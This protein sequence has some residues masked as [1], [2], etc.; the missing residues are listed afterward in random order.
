MQNTPWF[1]RPARRPGHFRL[2]CLSYAGG[3]ARVFVPWQAALGPDVEICAIELPGR[4]TRVQETA[5]TAMDALIRELGRAV[6]ALQPRLPFAFFGHSLGALIA[7]E[8]AH[9][10]AASGHPAPERLFASGCPAPR[11]TMPSPRLHDLPDHEL[12]Q[13]LSELDGTPQEV[14]ANAEF[15]ALVLPTIRADL[16]ISDNYQ[17]LERTLLEVPITVF[18]G[19]TDA[20]VATHQLAD[21]SKETTGPVDVQL[22]DGG[23]FFIESCRDAVLASVKEALPSSAHDGQL[24]QARP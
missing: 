2:F 19:A 4:S 20:H 23:H 3:G 18:G 5:F 10:F 12:L 24:S 6:L 7:F 8:L 16:A 21:W 1:V 11:D 17:Y 14:L 22:F 9:H 13:A 15:M